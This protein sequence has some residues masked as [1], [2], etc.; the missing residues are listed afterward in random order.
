MRALGFLTVSALIAL[1]PTMGAADPG[2]E[3]PT[4]P[5]AASPTPPTV[6]IIAPAQQTASELVNLDE[7]VCRNEAPATGTRLGGG[8][9]CRTVRE[10]KQREQQAQDIT[11]KAEIVGFVHH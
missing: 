3:Q 4:P 1:A 2:A 11:R 9:E 10:W 8:R 6:T 5:Q 7:V